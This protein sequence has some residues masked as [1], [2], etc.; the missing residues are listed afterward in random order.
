[1]PEL[2]GESSL[3]LPP[4]PFDAWYYLQQLDLQQ[5][6]HLPSAH[7]AQELQEVLQQL[8]KALALS[9]AMALE[10]PK[11][12]TMA[13]S[14]PALMSVWSVFMCSWCVMEREVFPIH[15]VICRI[16]RNPPEFF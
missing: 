5:S 12:A 8:L 14:A 7:F 9:A 6:A 16:R 2:A 15:Q 10:S 1:M 3:F 4:P 13:S 11:P